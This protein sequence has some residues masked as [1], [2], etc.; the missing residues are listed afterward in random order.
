MS[1]ISSLLDILAAL[2]S[3]VAIRKYFDD[4][5]AVVNYQFID[6][7]FHYPQFHVIYEGDYHSWNP[8]ITTPPGLYYLTMFLLKLLKLDPTLENARFINYLGGCV[9]VSLVY[10]IRQKVRSPGFTSA[11]TV[12]NPLL[13]IFYSLYYTDVWST[14]IIVAAYAVIVYRPFNSYIITAWLSAFIGLISLTF[15]Q[16]N[17]AWCIFLLAIIIDDKIKDADLYKYQHGHGDFLTFMKTAVKSVSIVVPYAIVG[18]L[19]LCFVYVNGGVPLGDK[20]NHIL[21]PHLAQLCYCAT[22]ITLFTVPIWFSFDIFNDYVT[23]NL[24]SSQALFFNA[25][26]IPTLYVIVQNFTIIH[27]FL[28]ADNRH[29][30]FY[31]VRKFITR[32]ES[33]R[34]E[35]IPIYHFSFYVIYK[36]FIQSSNVGQK[37]NR[38]EASPI[39]F[40]F[41]IF[42]TLVSVALSPLIEP[43]YYILPYLFFRLLVRPSD[44]PIFSNSYLKKYNTALRYIGEIVW[45]WFWTQTIYTIFLEYT[46]PWADLDTPQRIIW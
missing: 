41:Y 12:L 10:L 43:R 28:L 7:L 33:S 40:I 20:D 46:F 1:S 4:I 32:S 6:E 34:L 45:L 30:T 9:L 18:G 24:F 29:Y 42:S 23:D 37:N 22:F 19:F 16:T 17:I 15:R 21:V 31:L 25:A 36:L 3:T 44:Q 26:W 8:K 27:P 14:T 35:L 13:T 2:A 11:S 39:L 5:S 38:S